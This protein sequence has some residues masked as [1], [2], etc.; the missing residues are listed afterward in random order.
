L[1][2]TGSAYFDRCTPILDQLDELEGVIQ[3]RQSELAGTIRLTASTAFGSK[4]LIEALRPFQKENP[5]VLIDLHLS[6]KRVSIVEDGFDVAIR[7]GE[8]EDS[9]LVARKLKSMRGVVFA[10]PSYLKE[11]GEPREPAALATHN[12]LLQKESR[13]PS[14][15]AFLV[16]GKQI[17]VGVS[18]V[19]KANSP[20]AVAHMA[21]GGVGIGRGPMYVVE[22]FLEDGS[23]KLL[24]EE[25]ETPA[26]PLYAVYPPGR[27][28]TAR[29]RALIDHLV[30][31][32]SN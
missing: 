26:F 22:P 5:L 3:R 19:F 8:L 31:Y 27:H 29:I 9:T 14:N 21:A 4:E 23:L 12:C 6:D 15:W 7:F 17:S 13:D 2:E 1:T 32:F 10:S 24:F 20:R 25:N 16:D 28:L 30:T 11:Y 18:G